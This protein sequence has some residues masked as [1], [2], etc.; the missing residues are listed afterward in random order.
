MEV[1]DTSTLPPD[2]SGLSEDTRY[3][4][5]NGLDCC[6]TSEIFA[7]LTRQLDEVD[8]NTYRRGM[9][10]AGRVMEMMLNG[11]LVDVGRRR[12][13]LEEFECNL[14]SL[15]EMFRA[16]CVDGLGLDAPF[17]HQS[18]TQVQWFF[19]EYLGLKSK[20][21]RNKTGGISLV[22][23]RDA[24]EA[25]SIYPQ[26]A[27]FIKL[28]L[29]M[30][31]CSKAIGFL[32]T[33]L[34]S[35]SRMRTSLNVAGTNTGRL[36]SSF[37]DN[38]NGTNLQNIDGS[39]K[40]IFIAPSGYMIVDVDAEQADSRNVAAL[41]WNLLVESHGA[42][43]AGRY[44]D[45]CESGD[46]HTSVCRMAWE[47]LAWPK[48]EAFESQKQW[49]KASKLIAE[50]PAYREMSYRDLAKRLG[51]GTNYL[52]QAPQMARAAHLKQQLVETFQQ[53][54]FGGFPCIKDWQNDTIHQLQTTRQIIN[55][56]GRRRTFWDDPTAQP[57]INA[58][59]AYAPQGSTGEFI[60]EGWKQL[61]QARAR[62]DWDIH[63]LLQVHDSLVF[64]VPQHLVNELLPTLLS[65]MLVTI[66]LRGGRDFSIPLGCKV[67]WNYG[68]FDYNNPDRNPYG[69]KVFS[70][71]EGELRT[72]P[73]RDNFM[74]M[75][76]RPL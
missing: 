12:E 31:D 67:G 61:F 34:D 50:M 43:Y 49:M 15:Q 22:S 70:P 19:Y 24:L 23:D 5:Y 21:K 6:L 1:I 35:D 56:F 7:A 72:P 73:R 30:R 14:A 37:A 11:L 64:L 46:L 65:T 3:W 27:P 41:A 25:L 39:L 16:I 69:L 75:L 45:A 62:F 53:R 10:L 68:K 52:G 76:Q 20:R 74:D 57:T 8:R 48:R 66:P 26:A 42:E 36:N 63:F 55:L 18:P 9:D 54:Y 40:D 17:N 2:L 51:H 59:I 58:A 44:L 60:N 13:V 33:K 28:I 29:A 71:S 38:G 32:R 47:D 4:L